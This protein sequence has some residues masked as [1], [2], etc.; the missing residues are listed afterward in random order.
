[1]LQAR[2]Y[3][4]VPAGDAI[5]CLTRLRK[6]GRKGDGQQEVAPIRERRRLGKG[7]P[8]KRTFCP[9]IQIF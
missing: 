6:R 1:M 9:V 5:K 3:K 2:C 4:P 7:N 8:G